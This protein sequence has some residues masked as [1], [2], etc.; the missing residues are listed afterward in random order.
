MEM[1]SVKH[2]LWI[3]V[4]VEKF[5]DLVDALLKKPNASPEMLKWLNNT[6]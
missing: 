5:P 1:A 3:N 2:I 4:P 6:D